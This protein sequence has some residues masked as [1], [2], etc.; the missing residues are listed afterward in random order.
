MDFL[1]GA[2]R[3]FRATVPGPIRGAR[4]EWNENGDRREARGSAKTSEGL[5]PAKSRGSGSPVKPKVL[6]SAGGGWAIAIVP[7]SSVNG[8]QPRVN[9]GASRGVGVVS[10]GVPIT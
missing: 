7:Q 10:S 3:S 4:D 1:R 9:R 6:R 8:F 5:H 2:A